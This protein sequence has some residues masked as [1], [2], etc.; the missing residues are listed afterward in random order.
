MSNTNVLS[1]ELGK[2]YTLQL[3]YDFE[4]NKEA[5]R[6]SFA[7]VVLYLV[8]QKSSMNISIQN[9]TT[10]YQEKNTI[11]VEMANVTCKE[12]DA[13]MNDVNAVQAY[14]EQYGTVICMK[15]ISA[16]MGISE[17]IERLIANGVIEVVGEGKKLSKELHSDKNDNGAFIKKLY[18][19][20]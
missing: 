5:M 20:E 14:L 9:V 4:A 16:F 8:N 10:H 11:L 17:G 13:F 7:E 12:E 19:I 1:V 18:S 15:G 2:S 6:Y 3:S